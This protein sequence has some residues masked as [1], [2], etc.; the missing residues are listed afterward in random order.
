MT[1]AASSGIISGAASGAATGAYFGPIGAA[2]GG[3]IGG[4]AGWI[5]GSSADA[6][7]SN[8]LAWAEYNRQSEYNTTVRNIETSLA[9]AGLNAALSKQAASYNAGVVLDAAVY[10]AE[11]IA[12]TTAYNEELLDNE[13]T[14][15]WQNLDLDIQ[16]IEMFRARERGNMVVD[17]AASGTTIGQDSN[18]I[19]II[20]QQTQESMD[21]VVTEFGAD[22]QAANINNQLAQGRWQG[23]V[24]IQQTMWEGQ[25]QANS[26]IYNSNVQAQGA[27]AS[28][29]LQA[30][31]GMYS[32]KQAF[33]TGGYNQQQAKSQFSSQQD[34]AMISGLFSAA[35]TYGAG[36]YAR[37][38]PGALTSA[39]KYT[40]SLGRSTGG[41][42]FSAPASSPWGSMAGVTT[43]GGAGSSLLTK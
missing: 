35:S 31:A 8:Q 13:L 28:A 12:Q 33:V 22:R 20:D 43:G 38:V 39:G 40:T 10:N 36:V 4:V 15:V 18:A 11:M 41:A 6:Q 1:S 14:R 24:A 3:I 26:I 19:A 32:A 42:G 16:Q 21:V 29:V 34:Q 37:K 23:E 25:V 27:L 9:I 5:S 17:Q 2:A 30:D 7:F